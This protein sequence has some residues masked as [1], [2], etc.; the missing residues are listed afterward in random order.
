MKSTFFNRNHLIFL[1]IVLLFTGLLFNRVVHSIGIFFACIYIVT[2]SNW[3]KQ[4]ITDKY[5]RSFLSL[6]L[7]ILVSDLI[8]SS[9]SILSSTFFP[10]LALVVYPLMIKLWNPARKEISYVLLALVVV[11][12]VNIFYGFYHLITDYDAI[13]DAYKRAKVLPTL[14]LGDHIRMS[15][16]TVT[17]IWGGVYLLNSSQN[18]LLDKLLWG[19]ILVSIIYIHILSVKTGL[20]LLYGSAAI[21]V[22]YLF[23]DGNIKYVAVSTLL[24]ILIPIAAFKFFPSLQNRVAYIVWDITQHLKGNRQPGLSDGSRIAS[25]K[26]GW[27]TGKDNFLSGVGHIKLKEVTFDWYK[28][29]EPKM[30]GVDYIMPSSQWLIFF[31]S[32][33]IVG[34]L[35]FFLHLILPFFLLS[36]SEGKDFYILYI[37]TAFTFL[38]ETHL[39]GQYAIFVYAFFTYLFF[40]LCKLG[41]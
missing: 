35:I 6:A 10:K 4:L 20:L 39:E 7:I 32:C 15:W 40:H 3:W 26:A 24:L 5:L 21:Y 16:I 27:Q 8:H 23:R 18:N 17:G 13:I 31:A 14:A 1:S 36:F 22:L 33:G 41:K 11:S 38:Y 30:P 34:V 29:N 37:P 19:F 12:L 28:K 25:L 9:G 2:A